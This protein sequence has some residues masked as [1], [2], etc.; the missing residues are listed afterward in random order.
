MLVTATKSF[1]HGRTIEA[2]EVVD[3]PSRAAIDLSRRGLVTYETK[4]ITPEVKPLSATPFRDVPAADAKP[5][6]LV[7]LESAVRS[8]SDAPE[9]R[10]SRRVERRKGKHS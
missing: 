2:G 10:D 3:M 6:A 7:A 1:F 9:Q 8:V 5:P 4:V